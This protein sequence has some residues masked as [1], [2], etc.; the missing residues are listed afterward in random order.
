MNGR[1]PT[2]QELDDSRSASRGAR[3]PPRSEED[4]GQLPERRAPDGC[5][6]DRRRRHRAV[7]K[8]RNIYDEKTREELAVE[9][10]GKFAS[11]VAAIHRN[12]IGE[13]VLDPDPS[14][15]VAADFLQCSPVRSPTRSRRA[16][17]TCA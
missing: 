9:F 3:A 11:L 10:I 13:P 8:H 15:P 17:W 1:L 6:A 16:R 5:A 12:R 4:P 14:M 7:T 2:K